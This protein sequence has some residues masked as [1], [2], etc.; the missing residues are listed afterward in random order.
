M[1]ILS[2]FV[3]YCDTAGTEGT[4][5]PCNLYLL[6][7]ASYSHLFR[8]IGSLVVNQNASC[9]LDSILNSSSSSHVAAPNITTR[10]NYSYNLKKRYE[11][12]KLELMRK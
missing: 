8:Y 12:L 6:Q 1:P 3:S 11:R 2:C 5:F 7:R 4:G 9:S 10:H